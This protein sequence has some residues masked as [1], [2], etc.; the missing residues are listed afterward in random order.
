MHVQEFILYTFRVLRKG[1]LGS[2]VRFTVSV[3][4]GAGLSHENSLFKNGGKIAYILSSPD[5][6]L[7]GASCIGPLFIFFTFRVLSQS[8]SGCTAV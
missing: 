2:M 4:G 1:W 7:V 3:L 6:A 8:C 5:P